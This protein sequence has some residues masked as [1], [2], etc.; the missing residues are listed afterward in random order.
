MYPFKKTVVSKS[1]LK[2][3][4]ENI[5]IGGPT[6][7]RASAKNFDFV[8]I[9]I[10]PTDYEKFVDEMK[11]NKNQISKKTRLDL[12]IKAFNEISLYDMDISNWFSKKGNIKNQNFVLQ[13]KIVKN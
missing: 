3:C 5:D 9:V 12:A 10:D 8:T 4:I 11:K 2:E 6:L 13:S 7:I 1:S